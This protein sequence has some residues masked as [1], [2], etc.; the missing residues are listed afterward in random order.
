MKILFIA[1]MLATSALPAIASDH[2]LSKQTMLTLDAAELMMDATKGA[3]IANNAAVSIAIVDQSGTL[4]AFEKMDGSALGSID[5]A[6]DK[7]TSSVSFGVPTQSLS[8]W[9]FGENLE[10]GPLPF[11]GTSG[12]LFAL[13]GGQ[14]IYINN[15]LVGGIGVSG[16]T[17]PKLDITIGAAG[18]K[19]LG[20]AIN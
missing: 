18:I 4:I 1:T 8:D 3:A 10:G 16:A 7:S 6:I 13:G 5:F 12:E 2:L 20:N 9:A 17:T 19:A 15:E 14:P 11:I